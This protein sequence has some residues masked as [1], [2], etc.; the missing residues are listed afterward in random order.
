MDCWF[1]KTFHNSRITKIGHFLSIMA[2][3]V[4]IFRKK[5]VITMLSVLPNSVIILSKS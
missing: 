2:R 5:I 1:L 3:N 4:N